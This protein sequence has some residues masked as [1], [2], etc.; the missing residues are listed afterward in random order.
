MKDLMELERESKD[1][2]IV[3]DNINKIDF[4]VPNPGFYPLNARTKHMDE[5]QWAIEKELTKI[6]E[7]NELKK[8]KKDNLTVKERIGLKNPIGN[9]NVVIRKSDKGGNVVLLDSDLYAALVKKI[10]CNTEIYRQINTNPLQDCL[11]ELDKLL[12]IGKELG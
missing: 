10:L 4:H 12:H 11:K 5:F 9:K 2:S 3:T 1:E 6:K 8:K 7:T